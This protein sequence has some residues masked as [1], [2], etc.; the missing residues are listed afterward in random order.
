MKLN[1]TVAVIFVVL[2][3]ITLACVSENIDSGNEID[4]A[5]ESRQ[6]TYRKAIWEYQGEFGVIPKVIEELKSSPENREQLENSL[7]RRDV[8]WEESLFLIIENK[9]RILVPFLGRGGGNV[10]GALCLSRNTEGKTEWDMVTR[11]DLVKQNK[12]RLPFWTRSIWSGYF[13]AWEKDILNKDNGHPGMV[14]RLNKNQGSSKTA[15]ATSY[16]CDSIYLGENCVSSG[17]GYC[18]SWGSEGML[19]CERWRFEQVC[20][21]VY[22]DYCYYVDDGGD[23]GDDDGDTNDDNGGGYSYDDRINLDDS[24]KLNPKT[25]C[26][27]NQLNKNKTIKT[28]LN[29]F[30]GDDA[31]FDLN[32]EVINNLECNDAGNASGCTENWLEI[33]GSITIKIDQDYVNS[34]KVPTLFIARTIIH[35]AIHANLYL[36]IYNYEKGNQANIPNIDD[37]PAI[38]AK[39]LSVRG[40]QHELMANLYVGLIANALKDVHPLLNDQGYINSLVDYDMS[41]DD[42]YTNIAYVGLNGTAGQTNYLSDPENAANYSICYENSR[43]NSTTDANCN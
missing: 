40:L 42:F 1:Y 35:E 20:T 27:Y 34:E 15:R 29:D 36:A 8:L 39:Y 26:T 2:L 37:F 41:L 7:L 11:W 23:Y 14:A 43:N 24:F 18:I 31:K 38:F 17:A 9:K 10:V 3:S 5:D 32:F 22:Q 33:N 16:V 13:M 25:N 12:V 19:D 4:L 28:L 30:F 21:P 6:A